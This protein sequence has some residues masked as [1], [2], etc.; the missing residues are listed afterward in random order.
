MKVAKHF[1][2]FEDTIDKDVSTLIWEV[3]Y[4]LHSHLKLYLFVKWSYTTLWPFYVEEK[5]VSVVPN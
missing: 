5:G 1:E 3:G 2:D 4:Y